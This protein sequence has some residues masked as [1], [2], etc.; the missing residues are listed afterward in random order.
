[1]MNGRSVGL[2]AGPLGDLS[3]DDRAA[4]AVLH[5][6]I[7]AGVRCIDTA[8]S[9]GASEDRIGRFFAKNPALRKDVVL[10][11]KGGYGVAGTSDWS[12][13]CIRGGV[14]RAI[15]RLGRVD[16]FVLHS[17][18]PR[19]DLV[20]P[21]LEAKR[22]ERVRA[23]GYSGDGEGLAWA[24]R[25]PAFDVIECS[26]NLVDQDALR[27]HLPSAE[28]RGA[29]ILGKRSLANAAWN[30]D[31]HVYSTRLRELFPNGPPLPWD[32]LAIRFAAHAPAVACALVGTTRPERI[33]RAVELSKAGPLEAELLEYVTRAWSDRWGPVI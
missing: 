1:M 4:E 28:A 15:E 17:C 2:G 19:P 25:E 23:I 21:L 7:E 3:L 18:P 12:A 6:A 30:Q 5:A 9:Y 22:R 14:E 10:V 32:E 13:E 26:V 8:P 31:G 20:E 11:T 24:A 27:H 16:V 29:T 33:T